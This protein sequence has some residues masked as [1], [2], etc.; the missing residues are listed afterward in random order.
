MSQ[1]APDLSPGQPQP[2]PAPAS[3]PQARRRLRSHGLLTASLLLPGIA[4]A[5]ALALWWSLSTEGGSRWL[6]GQVPDLRVEEPQGALLGDFSARRLHW[7]GRDGLTLE[8]SGLRWHRLKLSW[9]SSP[10]LW[11][12]I[13]VTS[14]QAERVALNWP[15]SAP[16]DSALPASLELP[17]GL[18]VDSLQ[19]KELQ[20]P[21]L[22]S[23][24]P[25]RD[26][27]AGVQL[28]TEQGL[29]HRLQL[30]SLNWDQWQFTGQARIASQRDFMLQADVQARRG[31]GGAHWQADLNLQGP[32]AAPQAKAEVSGAGQRL[33]ASAEL[34]PLAAWPL[35]SAELRADKLDLAGLHGSLP[36]T[37][38]SGHIQLQA[39][40]RDTPAFVKARL[41]NGLAGRWDQGRLA[42]RQ[43][44][45]DVQGR[46]DQAADLAQLRID[47]LDLELGSSAEPGGR[48]VA[49]GSAL[50]L[51][52]RVSELRPAALDARLPSVQLSGPAT[53][54]GQ[55]STGTPLPALQLETALSG[56]WNSARGVQ[57]LTLTLTARHKDRRLELQQARLSAG[58]STLE[59]RGQ[60]LLGES[61]AWQLD[62]SASARAFDPRLLWAGTAGSAWQRG[63]HELNLSLQGS[64]QQPG[65]SWPRWPQGQARLVLEPSLLNGAALSG[66]LDYRGSAASGPSTG[67]P[68]LQAELQ[69]GT[70]TLKL[71]AKAPGQTSLGLD[72]R[73]LASLQPV[74]A[75]WA[76]QAQLSGSARA[77]LE[78]M[79][80]GEASAE[81]PLAGEWR[82]TGQVSIEQLQLRGLPGLGTLR[83]ASAAL[84]LDAGTAADAALRLD[85]RMQQ[86]TL[87][88]AHVAQ[89]RLDL[90]GSWARHR[91]KIDSQGSL[92]LPAWATVLAGQDGAALNAAVNLEG[93]FPLN[94]WQARR[95]KAAMDWQA[96]NASVLL[97]PGKP[98]L[99]AWLD[100]ESLS[101]TAR[102]GPGGDLQQVALAPG[103]TELAGA[104][105]RWRQ[106]Q[107]QAPLTAGAAPLV[108][109][110]VEL[111]P[112]AVAPLL[113][114]WQP[115]FGW[116]GDL[117]MGGRAV[118]R[119]APEVEIDIAMQRS[120]GDLSVT[121][122]AGV[123]ALGLTEL[124]LGLLARAGTWHFTQ[125]VAGNNLGVLGGALTA[126]ADPRAL[127]PGP[128]SPL[129]GV[130][131]AQVDKLGSWG[132]W[133]PPGWR[134]AGQ[135][136]A[137]IS[138]AG[139]LGAPEIKG[140]A[141]GT[142]IGLRNPL[143]GV[144]VSE[145]SFAMKLE[146]ETATLERLSAKG[147]TGT[148]SAQGSAE[149][150]ASPKARLE[151][152]ADKFRLLG[153][154]DRR[155]TASGQA[156]L[157]LG[158]Q[159]LKLE[160]RFRADE[161]LFD[162]SRAD[163][164]SLDDDVRVRRPQ[165]VVTEAV[166][167]KGKAPRQID[168]RLALDLGDQL[169][170]F[171]RGLDTRLRGE[172]LLSHAQGRPT[173]TGTVRT[174]GGT[175]EAYGQKLEIEKGEISFIG[176]LDNPRLDVLAVRPN[177]DV[178]VGVTLG[179]SAQNPRVKLY[180]EP[181]M[182]ETD[183]LSWLLL[184]R[185]PEGLGRA[186]TALLQRAA[187]ALLAGEG[188]S[189]SGK[190]IKNLGLDDISVAQDADETRGTVVRL[191]KQ[192]SNRWYVG[193][194]RSLNA[195]TGSWQLIYRIAQ[196]FT[197]RA[198]S[199][200]Q[201]AVDLIW[202]WKWQ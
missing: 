49:K 26:L 20:F 167:P 103:R 96:R 29:Q 114:R 145:G 94:P 61:G 97:R 150:G 64:L 85:A 188:E 135:F 35:H 182:A 40:S 18:R 22:G 139:R 58:G 30:Q 87:G 127:W 128:D 172:L 73:Q 42:L 93:S 126:R 147:G 41:S 53:L 38:L 80:Q 166:A 90:Q 19:I 197:L 189:P 79:P 5:S 142:N 98:G 66:A 69:L 31:G 75:L 158:E 193:Y 4:A 179:G 86:L 109:A 15:D 185:G 95:A 194:E 123:Q 146:G 200:E 168:L 202:Q 92:P 56:V 48:I 46:P 124:R 151:L 23:T 173:L 117:V 84:D 71:L 68:A 47:A 134:L 195:T 131:S 132:A 122:D 45:L 82:A 55:A 43:L 10:L 138:L 2:D 113:A 34:R 54:K 70:N 186:D 112:L 57:P 169:R 25:L 190:L 50:D 177:T 89:S 1:L 52:A 28:G 107:W 154:V 171:G 14:M 152:Q 111:A 183:K 153:R 129:E 9:T 143:L 155:L 65:R 104:L 191:G 60:A 3:A 16:S 161:G 163:A 74:L 159:S 102:L 176:P 196:R 184:G 140:Q 67:G 91:L 164:P 148:F 62:G 39:S 37:A 157:D 76:P 162:F 77:Q 149:L 12:Q 133:L 59:A 32:L 36:A 51:Q 118:L 72:A 108:L 101:M 141:E 6:L 130:L 180:S 11:A 116:G 181:E 119:S 17:F 170:V 156:R 7:Q 78:L 160:G 165:S 175:Y 83:L 106:L 201:N 174:A 125:A 192:L 144:D 44:T 100:A 178:R 24:Q 199:G 27:Q 88:S 187:L 99:P 136:K 120:D 121:D 21:G 8:I 81:K 137:G 13:D 115:D 33:S 110:D 198:Q 63:R 105:L